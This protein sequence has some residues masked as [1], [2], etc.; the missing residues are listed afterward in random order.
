MISDMR[1]LIPSMQ[2][3]F[4]FRLNG[5]IM[6]EIFVQRALVHGEPVGEWQIIVDIDRLGKITLD[7]N[8][9]LWDPALPQ[10]VLEFRDETSWA[11]LPQTER[12]ASVD[13]GWYRTTPEERVEILESAGVIKTESI[14]KFFEADE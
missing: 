13:K 8:S 14:N 5:E 10:F 12:H 4:R 1:N 9:S 3:E 2:P 7:D 11:L 6:P